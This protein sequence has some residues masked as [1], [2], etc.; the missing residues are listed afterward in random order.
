[1]ADFYTEIFPAEDGDITIN[2][3]HGTRDNGFRRLMTGGDGDNLIEAGGYF[4][5]LIGGAGADTLTTRFSY[6]TLEGGEGDDYILI[7]NSGSTNENISHVVL[8]GGAGRDTFAFMP[9]E[10]TI[11]ATI[12]DF[13]PAEDSLVLVSLTADGSL[14]VL[15][16]LAADIGINENLDMFSYAL[17]RSAEESIERDVP[18]GLIYDSDTRAAALNLPYMGFNLTF[19]GIEDFDQLSQAYITIVDSEGTSIGS[20][21]THITLPSGLSIYHSDYYDEDWIF[22]SSWYKGDVYLGGVD[23]SG[24]VGMGWSDTTITD[25]RADNDTVSGRML[26]GDTGTNYI[27]AGSGG[28]SMWGGAGGSDY[29][30]GGAGADTFIAATSSVEGYTNI[31]NADSNDIVYLWSI[32]SS[33]LFPN[34]QDSR[35][36]LEGYSESY[37]GNDAYD[38]VIQTYDS[39]L[40]VRNHSYGMSMYVNQDNETDTT[41]LYLSDGYQLRYDYLGSTWYELYESNWRPLAFRNGTLQQYINDDGY[42]VLQVNP[43]YQGNIWLNVSDYFNETQIIDASN[44]ARKG[45]ILVGNDLDNTIVAGRGGASMWGGAGNAYLLGGAGADTFIAGK[46]EGN[47][48]IAGCSSDDIVMLRETTLDDIS[49]VSLMTDADHMQT[50]IRL[51][52]TDGARIDIQRSSETATTRVLFS[53]H[54]VWQYTY[55]DGGNWTQLVEAPPFGIDR[56]GDSI[57]L[58]SAYEGDLYL[59]GVDQ[60]G[61]TVDGW[62]DMLVQAVDASEDT[63]SGRMIAGNSQDNTIYAGANGA[64]MW[65]GAGGQDYLY[66]GAGADTFIAG[67]G[68]SATTIWRCS[69]EDIVVLR[70][71]NLE[72]IAGVSLYEGSSSNSIRI[73][74]SDG[75]AINIWYRPSTTTSTTIRYADGTTR[76]WDHVNGDWRDL[77][78]DDTSTMPGGLTKIGNSLYITSSYVGDIALSGVDW[79]DETIDGWSSSLVANVDAREDTVDGRILAG[80]SLDNT[81]RAGSGGATLW[82]GN[83]GSDWL[84][85]GAGSDTFIAAATNR[86]DFLTNMRNIGEGDIVYLPTLSSED[87]SSSQS[88]YGSGIYIEGISSGS[89]W[90]Y[91][92]HIDVYS[93]HL[94][95]SDNRYSSRFDLYAD[96]GANTTTLKFSDGYQL[97]YDYSDSHWYVLDDEIW[98]PYEITSGALS[99]Y[100]TEDGIRGISVYSNYVGDFRLDRYD[101]YSSIQIIDAHLD[102]V[103]GRVLVGNDLD[104]CIFAGSGGASLWGNGGNDTLVG[105]GGNDTFAVGESNTTVWNCSGNDLVVLDT[106]YESLSATEVFVDS[107]GDPLGLSM[108]MNSGAVLD[109]YRTSEATSTSVLFADYSIRRYNYSDRVWESVREP[110]PDGL[111]RDGDVITLTSSF[112]GDLYLGGVDAEGNTVESWTDNSNVTVDAREDTV[113]GRMLAGNAQSDA[114]CAGSGGASLWGGNGGSDEL[115]GGA[116]ADTFIAG[117]D[118]GD[119]NIWYCDD[120]D[121]V[122]FHNLNIANLTGISLDEGYSY[123]GIKMTANDGSR[124]N[125][126]YSSSTTLTTFMYADSSTRIF[127]HNEGNFYDLFADTDTSLP[128]GLLKVGNSLYVYSSFDGDLYLSGIGIDDETVESWTNDL[129]R[130]IDATN[131]TVHGRMLAGNGHYNTIYAGSGGAFMWAGEDAASSYLIGGAGADTF[132][133]GQ[134]GSNVYTYICDC[135]DDDL[136]YLVDADL[137][138]VRSISYRPEGGTTYLN[139]GQLLIHTTDSN[140]IFIQYDTDTTTKTTIRFADGETRTWDHINGNWWDLVSDSDTSMP[141]GITRENNTIVLS[142]DYADDLYLGGYDVEGNTLDGWSDRFIRV[143]DGS[144]NTVSGKMIAGN[145]QDNSIHAGSGG[146]SIWGGGGYDY[147]YGGAGADTFIAMN[148]GNSDVQ[149]IWYCNDDDIV[150]LYDIMPYDLSSSTLSNWR[151]GDYLPYLYVTTYNG[152]RIYITYD[153]DTTTK[154][155]IQYAN[156]DTRTWNHAD[157]NWEDLFFDNYTTLPSGLLKDGANITITSDYEG[158]VWLSGAD[159]N[160]ETVEGWSNVHVSDIDAREDTVGGRMLAGNAGTNK[161]YAGSGGVSLWGGPGGATNDYLYG[162]AGA[163]TFIAGKEGSRFAYLESIS[164][165]DLVVLYDI[166]PEDILRVGAT[167]NT[168]SYSRF[169]LTTGNYN[170]IYIDFDMNSPLTIQY[171]DGERRSYDPSVGDWYYVFA[172]DTADFPDGLVKVGNSACVSSSYVGGVYLDS[173]DYKGD[174]VTALSSDA[175]I[176]IDASNDTVHGRMLSGNGESNMIYAG[177]GGA[178]IWGGNGSG[179]YSDYLYG[180]AGADTFIA[181]Q[182]E[183]SALIYNFTDEDMIYLH[184][185]TVDDVATLDTFRSSYG[186]SYVRVITNDNTQIYAQTPYGYAISKADLMYSDG[187]VRRYDFTDQVWRTVD[188][189]SNSTVEGYSDTAIATSAALDDLWGGG[190]AVDDLIR[191]DVNDD[192]LASVLNVAGNVALNDVNPITT[193]VDL[194]D[195]S[196]IMKYAADLRRRSNR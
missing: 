114:I 157:G 84:Y 147:L 87:I 83:D 105:R 40:Y 179:E 121:V 95:L 124:I 153:S 20:R 194:V 6:V 193:A 183:G 107:G 53:D 51:T 103:S 69:D 118:G 126:W 189:S 52:L 149:N 137:D 82:G 56:D 5:T 161:I 97:R 136:I 182:G 132:V 188:P 1:M 90:Y 25:I 46:G 30:I 62:S 39:F 43:K 162:G 38:W 10:H 12:T 117:R 73:T 19:N 11:N 44:D 28:A 123:S 70:N 35:I 186:F 66:G 145:A 41:T 192:P 104:N 88:S 191:A 4:N 32:S 23:P 50:G 134:G 21:K 18:E 122:F 175:I 172:D 171:A 119:V 144:A 185:I 146:A 131:D 45:R 33:N 166:N 187:T 148:G 116:G 31:I 196:L 143:I 163:D 127:D 65:G 47:A 154:T 113:K 79:N 160:D 181:G 112:E 195:N 115:Y 89:A 58:T 138:D 98:K 61:N 110:L 48:T 177:S 7:D 22:V 159:W 101:Y 156:G 164:G 63:V 14:A 49:N 59:G 96:A 2:V 170:W 178:S 74:T 142:S 130:V 152:A 140:Q 93:N 94:H 85:G 24:N 27:F 92:W 29:L 155:T 3:Y 16:A 68:E 91:G 64:S 102:T 141:A 76:T 151:Y 128:A 37:D 99:E 60:N 36:Y 169:A 55:A 173:V 57:T 174:S 184:N 17:A 190:D 72:D 42:N 180:G 109:V 168:D 80:N 106:L 8:T 133:A 125:V 67:Q 120:D 158:N 26:A 54:S 78:I 150:V 81:I 135:T 139:H 129:I 86:Y 13:D 9:G 77:F 165:D 167:L 75:T 34:A 176:Y 111:L 71:I 15:Q 100:T 108:T